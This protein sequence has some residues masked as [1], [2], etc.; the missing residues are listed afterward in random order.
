MFLK[1][2]KT[3]E[4]P[5]TPFLLTVSKVFEPGTLKRTFLV[6]RGILY[7]T[8]S[9]KIYLGGTPGSPLPP[10]RPSGNSNSLPFPMTRFLD[11]KLL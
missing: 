8:R 4:T 3:V 5:L 7:I 9:K 2:P 6:L 11:E 1:N 10:P